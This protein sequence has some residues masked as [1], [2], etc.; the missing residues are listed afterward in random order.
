MA[1]LPGARRVSDGSV[2]PGP[3]PSMYAF[4]KVAAQRN[5]YRVPLR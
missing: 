4:T 1:A 2:Y 3:D 5:I